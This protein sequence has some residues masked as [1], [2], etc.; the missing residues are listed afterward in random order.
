M[1]ANWWAKKCAT[2]KIGVPLANSF[3]IVPIEGYVS[4]QCEGRKSES[5]IKAD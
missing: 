2:I 1:Y 5:E 4:R 3:N